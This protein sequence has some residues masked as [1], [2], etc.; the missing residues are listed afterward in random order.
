MTSPDFTVA[1][2]PSSAT[3]TARQLDD[4]RRI[5]DRDRGQHA[6]HRAIGHGLP[7]GVT[8]SF[9]PASVTAGG[10]STLTVTAASTAA[11]STSSL[12]IKGT[13]GATSH[14]ASASLTVGTGGGGGGTLS[15]GVPVT[16]QSGALN[17]QANY[18]IAV[19]AGQTSLV[20][21][22]SGGTGDADLYVRSGSA[23]CV[24]TPRLPAVHHRQL[25]DVHVQQSR[26]GHLVHLMLNGYTAYSGVSLVATYSAAADTTP[27]LTNNVATTGIAGATGSQQYW[28]LTVPAEPNVRRVLDQQRDG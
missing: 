28:K 27:A 14:T 1:V 11:S 26:R 12:S 21:Q 18:S 24:A 25:R 7:T 2:S 6:E 20:V 23:P 15:N 13:S 9:S 22:I 19:P 16:N 17:A 3:V 4:V 10:S 8:G 5:D